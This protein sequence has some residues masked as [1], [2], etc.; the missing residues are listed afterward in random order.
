MVPAPGSRNGDP[1]S[2]L[3]TGAR[4]GEAYYRGQ[5]EPAISGNPGA[6]HNT[7][8]PMSAV[9]MVLGGRFGL[10]QMQEVSPGVVTLRPCRV[11]RKAA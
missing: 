4:F 7:G 6:V 11:R 3:E 1:G 8:T 10:L 9:A 5:E 2:I